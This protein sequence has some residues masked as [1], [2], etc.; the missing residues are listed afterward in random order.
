M[1]SRTYPIRAPPIPFYLDKHL[2]G[3]VSV[4][5]DS[6]QA[7]NPDA[8]SEDFAERM[9]DKSKNHDHPQLHI[10]KAKGNERP[11]SCLFAFPKKSR[12]ERKEESP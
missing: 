3:S 9:G 1:L 8:M 6:L 4:A 11:R 12:Q 10:R 2:P 7:E 5:I